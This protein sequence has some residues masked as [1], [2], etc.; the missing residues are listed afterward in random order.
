MD[1]VNSLKIKNLS[2]VHEE[3]PIFADLSFS[4]HEGELLLIEGENGSGK[5]SLLRILSGLAS[6]SA[7]LVLWNDQPLE[8]VRDDFQTELH[9]IGHQNGLKLGLTVLENLR[10]A[11]ILASSEQTQFHSVLT[12]LRLDT[13][14]NTQ[15]RFLSAGQKRRVALAKLFLFPKKLWLL[16]EPSTALDDNTQ[17]LFINLLENHVQQGGMVVMSSHH[18]F[19]FNKITPQTVRLSAC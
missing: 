14:L 1:A 8:S 11:S 5:S 12:Q 7:G 19:S 10:L 13:K 2:C 17:Q 4:L 6:S 3:Q 9:Y 15:T 18:H 16:D